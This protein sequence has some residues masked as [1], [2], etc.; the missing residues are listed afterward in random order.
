M[1]SKWSGW[2][3][4]ESCSL[5]RPDDLTIGSISG[6]LV[7]NFLMLSGWHIDIWTLSHPDDYVIV[8]ISSRWHMVNEASLSHPDDITS[9]EPM[10]YGWDST[11]SH[12]IPM[13]YDQCRMS[14]GWLTMLPHA[15]RMRLTNLILESSGWLSNWQYLIRMTYVYCRMSSGW[16]MMLPYVIRMR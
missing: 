11:W 8:S 6:W 15:I 2:H 16:L 7:T 13:T 1:H 4:K 12:L 5:S 10:S 3:M 14:S 9:V